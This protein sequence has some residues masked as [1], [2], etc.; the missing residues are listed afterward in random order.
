VLRQPRDAKR[1]PMLKA[2]NFSLE[3]IA[4]DR[5]H[6]KGRI[7][8]CSITSLG[9]INNNQYIRTIFL[10]VLAIPSMRRAIQ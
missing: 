1:I 3:A 2:S 8:E 7:P 9:K 5:S 6:H 10:I 4:F